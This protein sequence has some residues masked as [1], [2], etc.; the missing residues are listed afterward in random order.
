MPT[1]NP[2]TV[3]RRITGQYAVF[4]NSESNPVVSSGFGS[5]GCRCSDVDGD[6]PNRAR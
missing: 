1:E 2:L 6:S 4:I 3:E 5:A